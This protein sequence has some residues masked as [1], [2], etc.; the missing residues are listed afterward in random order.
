MSVASSE[1]QLSPDSAAP[2]PSPGQPSALDVDASCR[3]P[4]VF[5]L[6]SSLKWLVFALVLGAVASIK[7]HAPGFLSSYE[8]LTYGRV[9]PAFN[10]ALLFG[11]A[12]QA[13][14]A[15]SI[16]MLARLGRARAVAP[17]V[18]TLAS[19]V[20]N[21]GLAIG[22]VGIFMGD[23]TGYEWLELP[24][25][26]TPVLF[27]S[28]LT[29]SVAMMLTFRDRTESELYPSQWY[30]LAALL[31]F[32]WV[33]SSAQLLLVFGS[34][35]GV[36][37]SVV[38]GWAAHN[39]VSVWLT[40]MGLATLLYFLPKLSGQP[41]HSRG[42]AVFAFWMLVGVGGLGGVALGTPAPR[43]IS[44]LSTGGTILS[45]VAVLAVAANLF[46][47]CR[48]GSPNTKLHSSTRFFMA[49][50]VFYLVAAL[51]KI[52]AAHPTLH[53]AVRFTFFE[54][55][56][57]LLFLYGFLGLTFA[58]TIYFLAPKLLRIEWPAG[59]FQT[60]HFW[61]GTVGAALAGLP[62]VLGGLRQGIG[63]SDSSVAFLDVVRSTIPFLGLSTLGTVL[64]LI[65]FGGQLFQLSRMVCTALARC[66]CWGAWLERGQK[67]GAKGRGK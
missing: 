52:A 51:L 2:A 8:F 18:M 25:Y 49:G 11:F 7:L 36:L 67:S 10:N 31:W 62:L 45:V 48:A 42:L 24:G 35:R 46:L 50:G 55:G 61:L 19:W 65:G 20:W 63:L 4:V 30:I 33:Y 56:A 15:V 34:V 38:A 21:V 58:G 13:G 14:L 44:G 53:S 27:V 37:Q 64:V 3:V 22:V 59:G 12:A 1:T 54:P 57:G 9:K 39:L 47:T 41:L 60:S 23:A 40:S 17:F 6:G 66:E 16:W 26:A 5:M 29:L 32:P 28:A 43:W